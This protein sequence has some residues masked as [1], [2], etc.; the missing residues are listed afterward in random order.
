[1]FPGHG[2]AVPTIA[3]GVAGTSRESALQRDG[4]VPQALVPVTQMLPETNADETES[5]M[6]LVPCPDKIVV[7]AGGIHA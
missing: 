5:V 6:E 1:M 3:D 4:D 7:F 2:L